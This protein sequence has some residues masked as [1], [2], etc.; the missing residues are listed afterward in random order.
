LCQQAG[1]PT[2]KADDAGGV[3][4]IA[5]RGRC[6]CCWWC[7]WRCC[8][9][10]WVGVAVAAGAANDSRVGSSS[11]RPPGGGLHVALLVVAVIADDG[12]GWCDG[13][14]GRSR[15]RGGWGPAHSTHSTRRTPRASCTGAAVLTV[16]VGPST[17]ATTTPPGPPPVGHACCGRSRVLSRGV[18]GAATALDATRCDGVA[19]L[20]GGWGGVTTEHTCHALWAGWRG[21]QSP[22]LDGRPPI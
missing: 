4:N 15:H 1:V 20:R 3:F 14:S 9:L 13:T 18:E 2:H 19:A 17:T 7:C 6:W 5:I 8:W 22:H 21:R 11:R 12:D 16:L 10:R